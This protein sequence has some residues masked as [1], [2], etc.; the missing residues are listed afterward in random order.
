[1][2]TRSGENQ[3]RKSQKGQKKDL[4]VLHEEAGTAAG[5]QFPSGLPLQLAQVSEQLGDMPRALDALNDAARLSG[6]N[7]KTFAL[8]GYILAKME[9]IPEAHEVLGMLE[10]LGR[11]RYVPPYACAMIHAGLGEYGPAL[12]GL[13]RAFE[14]RDVHLAFLPND[15]KWDPLRADAQFAS[16]LKRCGFTF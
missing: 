10:A 7:S 13:E 5:A 6:G 9:R 2:P 15:V 1:M 4:S 14:M 11:E 12:D 3:I 16:L 8:R